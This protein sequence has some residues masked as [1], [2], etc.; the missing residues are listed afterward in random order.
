VVRSFSPHGGGLKIRDDV[1]KIDENLTGIQGRLN[2][3]GEELAPPFPPFCPLIRAELSPLASTLQDMAT[4]RPNIRDPQE[5]AT[6]LKELDGEI[7]QALLAERVYAIDA[8]GWVNHDEADPDYLGHTL[9]QTDPPFQADF[10]TLL[11]GG[12]VKYEPTL[13]D[14]VLTRNGEDFE[15]VMTAAR[16]VMGMA[17]VRARSAQHPSVGGPEG[18]WQDYS[19]CTMLLSI[20]SDRLRDFLVMTMENTEY[21]S[22]RSEKDQDG[23]IK[24]AFK[25][26]PGLAALATQSQQF[27]KRRNDIV[28]RIATQTARR[29]VST[30]ETQRHHARSGLPVEI[31]EPTFEEFQ[32]ARLVS[33][34]PSVEVQVRQLKDW[35]RCLI[36]ASNLVFRAE[37]ALRHGES[38]NRC[39]GAPAVAVPAPPTWKDIEDEFKH[40]L[41]YVR[42]DIK[43]LIDRNSGLNY[44]IALLIGCGCEMLAAAEGDIK[45]RRGERVFAE[46]LPAGDWRLLADRLYSALRDG[47]AH[48][49]DTKHIDIDG[50]PIQIYISSH[51]QDAMAIIRMGHG[52]GLAVGVQTLAVALCDKIDQFEVLL[53]Q[54][55]PARRLFKTAIEYQRT[56]LLNATE[57]A[58]WDRLVPVK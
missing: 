9:W 25:R 26:V 5:L 39:M 45:C 35:Y 21:D 3:T 41:G 19:V 46:L 28:H 47:L 52:L 53:R 37:N 27:K 42:G 17:I 8:Y 2:V 49:F 32:A 48:G 20:A 7:E 57:R 10:E 56:L 30:L 40:S 4:S 58:A 22:R 54:N 24:R 13:R 29:S 34:E 51:Y 50:K 1:C 15:A 38:Y 12:T 23:L 44:T 33:S 14:E 31:W 43:W 6:L 16:Q 55:E 11:G 36:E 18:F